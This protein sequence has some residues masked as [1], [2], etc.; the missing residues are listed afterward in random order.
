KFPVSAADSPGA[1]TDGGEVKI[2][3]AKL[4]RFKRGEGAICVVIQ[5]FGCRRLSRRFSYAST[6][7]TPSFM[8]C[9]SSTQMLKRRPT[10]SMCVVEV[11]GAPVC[12]PY[13]LPKAMWM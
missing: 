5:L 10:T 3:V 2:G 8:I 11:Q 9:S 7:K 6:R 4:T 1:V 13:G 12:S